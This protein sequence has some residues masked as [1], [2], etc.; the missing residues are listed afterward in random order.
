[1]SL[2]PSYST[3]KG[4]PTD[5]RLRNG[6]PAWTAASPPQLST[7]ERECETLVLAV[8]K[9]PL[10]PQRPYTLVGNIETMKRNVLEKGPLRW[11]G[12]GQWAPASLLRRTGI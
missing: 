5:G 1:M 8:S 7:V 12:L 10:H 9:T 4:S 2:L 11:A 3:V 6:V